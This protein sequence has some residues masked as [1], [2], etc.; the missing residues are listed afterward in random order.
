[1]LDDLRYIHDRDNQDALGIAGR[2]AAQLRHEF[3]SVPALGQVDID[4]VVFTGMGGSALAALLAKSWPTIA[5]PFEIVRNYELPSYVGPR[6]LVIASSYSGNTEETLNALEQAEQ[7]GAV[8]AVLASGGR[9]AE[10]ATE[11]QLPV[12]L[13]PQVPQPRYAVFYS[14]NALVTLLAEAGL[15]TDAEQTI[16]DLRSAADLIE[17]ATAEW[18]ATVPTADNSAKRLALEIIGKSLVIYGGPFLAPAAYK[19]K[20]S[21]NENAKH[22]A[23]T[24][25]YPEFN[26]N[27]FIGWSKQP[28]D[29]PYAVVDLRSNLEHPR[30][31]K[32]FEVSARLLSGLRPEAHVVEAVGQT[33]AEQ[34]LWTVAYGDFVTLYLALLNNLDPAP[35]DLI[36]TFKKKLND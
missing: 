26:H 29:K 14:L 5:M 25:Q 16:A 22:I 7:A 12:I 11:K 35:V 31:Q 20:I 1:M 36:E 13:L 24:N 21:C 23:W 9:L 34:L 3:S 4:N 33:M 8:I 32:R 28:V 27:E 10:I 30:V 2:Q 19:W 18:A 6:T 17:Q 15:L